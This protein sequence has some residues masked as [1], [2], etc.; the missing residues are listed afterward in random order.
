MYI[1]LHANARTT[2]AI[3]AEIQASDQSVATLAKQYGVHETTIRRW[4]FRSSQ[5]DRPHTR[6][7]LGQSTSSEEEALITGLRRDVRLGLDDIHEVMKRC[8][9]PKLSRSAVY[10]CLKRYNLAS[11]ASIALPEATPEPIGTFEET[12]FGFV[13]IDLK[14]LPRLRSL[15]SYV[16]VAIER[17]TRFVY[18]DIVN[19]RDAATIAGCLERFLAECAY[20]VHTIL[21][22]NGSEFT[23]RFAVNKPGKPY[24]RPS[25]NHA[26]DVLCQQHGIEHRLTRTYRPQTNGMVERFNRRLGEALQEKPLLAKNSRKNRFDTN[27]ERNQYIRTFIERYN[28]TRLKCLDYEAPLASLSKHTKQYTYEG[29]GKA[30]GMVKTAL[31]ATR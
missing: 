18:V 17:C 4:K 16:F 13:H 6:H 21:T 26:F 20:P 11:K 24:D 25:G 22:D 28:R 30:M 12:A 3:R 7:N 27:E 8:V 31:V 14:I 23:D 15:P 10:R 1:K 5:A 29:R 19:R 2:P 9:N